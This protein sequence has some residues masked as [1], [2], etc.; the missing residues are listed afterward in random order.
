MTLL[1][2]AYPEIKMG[3]RECPIQKSAIFYKI[4]ENKGLRG[5]VLCSTSHKESRSLTQLVPPFYPA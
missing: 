3:T 2:S 5:D 1:S 4:K